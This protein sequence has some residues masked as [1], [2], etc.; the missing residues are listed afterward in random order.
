MKQRLITGTILVLVLGLLIYFGEGEFELLFS[1]FCV[2]LSGFAAYEFTQMS[3]LGQS[4]RWFDILTIVLTL[5][6]S[7]MSVLS[8][9]ILMVYYIYIFR[10]LLMLILL[11]AILFVAVKD[12]TRQ[13]FG[14]QL[15]TI[16]YTSLGFIAF[17]YLR[18]LDINLI[19][20]LLLVAMI[21]DVFAYLIG[22]KFGKHRLAVNISP[23][24]SV[25]GAIAGLVF[26]SI[27]ATLYAFYM[28]V[29]E[30]GFIGILGLS[31]A[32]SMIAQV[33]DLIASKFKRE[34]GIKDYSNLFP[35]HGGVLD[36]FDSSMFAAI[37]LMLAVIILL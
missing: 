31:L 19:I 7:V 29:F 28:G 3:R 21:T 26:G 34:A 13:E 8:F 1:G 37:F 6:F 33:G 16:F 11:D 14:N 12:F 32:L 15:L 2:L 20:Y 35:G 24:K 5:A 9:D 4:F 17:A 23:K 36:R 27:V 10:F 30:F 25:E 18:K 22:I